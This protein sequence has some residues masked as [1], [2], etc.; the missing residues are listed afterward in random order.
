[1]IEL[2]EFELLFELLFE[3]S[4]SRPIL[5]CISYSYLLIHF[6]ILLFPL[7]SKKYTTFSVTEVFVCI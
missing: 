7:L 2:F 3:L 5:F 1:M 4:Y 6:P